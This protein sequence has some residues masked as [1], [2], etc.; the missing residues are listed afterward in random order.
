MDEE[1]SQ[2][3]TTSFRHG[4]ESIGPSTHTLPMLGQYC[5]QSA[6]VPAWCHVQS[7][8][9]VV[10]CVGGDGVD[11]GFGVEGGIR[12]DTMDGGAGD[13]GA[14]QPRISSGR[15][16]CRTLVGRLLRLSRVDSVPGG[17]IASSARTG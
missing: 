13:G 12:G 7:P 11:G 1:A 4:I 3:P 2:L 9:S 10:G 16:H 8:T 5:A 6:P 14:G 15:G 17:M